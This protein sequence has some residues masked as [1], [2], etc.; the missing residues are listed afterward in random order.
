MDVPKAKDHKASVIKELKTSDYISVR[1]DESFCRTVLD[2]II[3][4]RLRHLED[5]DTF[6]RL[7][8]CAE[9]PVSIRMKGTYGNN[10]IDR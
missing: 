5:R 9:V 8:L 6:H 10:E 2:L 7:K 3:I 4:D 1:R